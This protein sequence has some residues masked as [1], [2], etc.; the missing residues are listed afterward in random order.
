MTRS[1]WGFALLALAACGTRSETAFEARGTVEVPEADLATL[2]PARVR[3][4]LVEEG[5]VIRAGD[6]VAVL[7]QTDLDATLAAQRA[8]IATASANLRDLEAG[9]RPQEVRSAEGELQA[10]GAELDRVTKDAARIRELVAKDLDTRQA[11]DHADAAVRSAQGREQT[12]R[13]ALRL[14]QAGARPERIAAA[15]AE[16]STAQS[17]LGQIE[18]RASEL[19]LVAPSD[20]VVLSRNAEPGEVLAAGTPVAT[21]GDLGRRWVRVFLPQWLVSG[22]RPGQSVD[23]MTGDRRT[24]VGRVASINPK[25]EFTPRVAL[26]EQERSDLMF[27][28][29]VEFAS[30]ADAP[31]PGLWVAVRVGRNGG[32][33]Q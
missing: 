16:L 7:T 30:P 29:R 11:L 18:A 9:S 20:G 28:V 4:V 31:M 19:V 17:T 27:G 25:A 13:E 26:T 22:I 1:R 33:A 21:L 2:S 12:A 15:R 8:R 3:R 24:L 5:A 6:T 23:V 14:L 32:R 10:A